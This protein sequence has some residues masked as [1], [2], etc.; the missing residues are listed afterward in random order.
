MSLQHII[1]GLLQSEGELSGYDIKH[2]IESG[3]NLFWYADLSQIY[4]ALAAIEDNAWAASTPDPDNNR[5]RKVYRITPSGEAALHQ[6]LTSDL[7]LRQSRRPELARI[8]FG[9]LVPPDRLREQVSHLK[10]QYES[11]LAAI[12][13]VQHI[14]LTQD[15][16]DSPED[17]PYWLI[18]VDQGIRA[19]QAQ[20]DWCEA[21][22]QTLDKLQSANDEEIT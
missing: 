4:R 12:Q 21:T 1:L 13:H 7:K 15:F 17:A 6:W 19:L 11:R 5:N 2:A 9:R 22:L 20:V 18:T 16:E 3:I 8:F 10:A 14:I